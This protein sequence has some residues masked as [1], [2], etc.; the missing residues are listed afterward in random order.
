M[1]QINENLSRKKAL[2]MTVPGIGP[3]TAASLLGLLPELGQLN[4]KQVASL[5]KKRPLL[6][7]LVAVLILRPVEESGALFGQSRNEEGESERQE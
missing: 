1:V 6:L 4:R 3:V 7:I 5:F 2:L